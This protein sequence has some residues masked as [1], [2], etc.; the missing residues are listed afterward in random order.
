MFEEEQK[1]VFINK[2]EII[3]SL[4]NGLHEQGEE[5]KIKFDIFNSKPTENAALSFQIFNELNTTCIQQW[6]YG[7]ENEFL[8]KRGNMN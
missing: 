6:Y 8:E 3:T 5:L 2:I 4:P 7:T 1:E